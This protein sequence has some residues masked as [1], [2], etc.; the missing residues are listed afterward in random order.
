MVPQVAEEGIHLADAR[1]TLKN[2]SFG[3]EVAGL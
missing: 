2:D 1:P 3:A